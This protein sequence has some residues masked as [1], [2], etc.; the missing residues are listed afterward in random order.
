MVTG[1]WNASTAEYLDVST[2]YVATERQTCGVSELGHL[3]LHPR[4]SL[5]AADTLGQ[6]SWPMEASF[7]PTRFPCIPFWSHRPTVML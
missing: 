2:S 6:V 5:P 7:F 3:H 4:N 1:P